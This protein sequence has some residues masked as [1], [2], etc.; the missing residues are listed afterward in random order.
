MLAGLKCFED[1]WIHVDR[2][3]L[4]LKDFIVPCLDGVV[5][6]LSEGG[7]HYGED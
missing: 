7:T 2:Q 5:N 3:V 6:P 4:L 1:F